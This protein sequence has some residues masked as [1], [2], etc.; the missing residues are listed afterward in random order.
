MRSADGIVEFGLQKAELNR[1]P[2]EVNEITSNEV[3]HEAC[4]NKQLC[5]IGFLPQLL[6]CQSECR[7]GYLGIMKEAVKKHRGKDWG[8]VVLMPSPFA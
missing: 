8:Y 6:D 4:D 3:L 2:P 5:I 1:P 7:K